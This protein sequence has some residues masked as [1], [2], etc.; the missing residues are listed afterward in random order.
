VVLLILVHSKQFQKALPHVEELLTSSESLNQTFGIIGAYH[1]RAD[2]ALGL[3]DFLDA[4]KKYG[5][6][7]SVWIG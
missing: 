2:C 3:K 7:N 5:I 6:A 4:E 1:Y